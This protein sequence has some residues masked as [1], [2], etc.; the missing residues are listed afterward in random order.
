[1]ALILSLD[2]GDDLFVDDQRIV[3]NNIRG[4]G[5]IDI[6]VN[7]KAMQIGDAEMTEVFPSVFI[8]AGL[9]SNNPSGIRLA[10]KAPRS[11]VILRGTLYRRAAEHAAVQ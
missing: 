5:D 9:L 6:Y 4:D 2:E 8:S 7:G 1:M 3:I 11:M 10:I